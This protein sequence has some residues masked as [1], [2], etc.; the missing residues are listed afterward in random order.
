LEK[1]RLAALIENRGKLKQMDV[2][3]TLEETEPEDE[4][5]LDALGIRNFHSKRPRLKDLV[6][7]K[8]NSFFSLIIKIC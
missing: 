3:Y 4:L 1:I 5:L 2:H 7:Y 8:R 6:V